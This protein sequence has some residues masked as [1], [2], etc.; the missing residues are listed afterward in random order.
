MDEGS[1]VYDLPM[2]SS[3]DRRPES[4]DHHWFDRPLPAKLETT[5]SL[6]AR[7]LGFPT[8]RV[9]IVHDDRQHTI[10]FFG[11]GD[12]CPI[13]RSESFCDVVVST[14]DWMAVPDATVDPRFAGLPS[15]VSGE[16]GAYL[17]VPLRGRHGKT[18][19]ALCVID[20]IG[21]ILD[22]ED[23][24]RLQQF[25]P[26]VEDQLDLMWQADADARN[27]EPAEDVDLSR[28]G[29]VVPWFRPVVGLSSRRTLG[30]DAPA[31]R[32]APDGRAT[33][34]RR[35]LIGDPDALL[36]LDLAVAGQAMA[37]VR[38]WQA[39][40]SRL[41]VNVNITASIISRPDCL[42]TMTRLTTD[43]GIKPVNV[44]IT[45]KE[46]PDWSVTESVAM[47]TLKGLRDKGF[48]II[49]D[50]FG[51]AWAG[52]DHMLWFPLD[53]IRL[54]PAMTAALGTDLGDRMIRAGTEIAHALEQRVVIDDIGSADQA[55]AAAALGCDRALGDLWGSA[56]PAS[57]VGERYVQ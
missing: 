39:H 40:D 42:A 54:D 5:L 50:G 2:L 27:V 12:F 26:V 18:V 48:G 56:Q 49:R 55:R 45:L 31:R 46:P 33:D 8:V 53:A 30:Y 13:D 9:N 17:G 14:G 28:P 25:A 32:V 6:A 10:G 36:A 52:L 35:R 20:P 16:I 57:A 47:A 44:D 3:G 11:A 41:T 1:G 29:S 34:P 51:T 21:R 4:G 24:W 38:G 19:G 15:V 37:V 43:A 7:A 22:D 23:I